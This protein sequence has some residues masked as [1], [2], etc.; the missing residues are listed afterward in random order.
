MSCSDAG[1]IGTGGGYLIEKHAE[2]LA[3]AG[4]KITAGLGLVG[5]R[6]GVLGVLLTGMGIAGLLTAELRRALHYPGKQVQLRLQSKGMLLVAAACLLGS[7]YAL[8]KGELWPAAVCAMS[9]AWALDAYR[10]DKGKS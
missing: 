6:L 2:K 1:A 8:F 5:R 3:A 4:E 7:A 9:G 10:R